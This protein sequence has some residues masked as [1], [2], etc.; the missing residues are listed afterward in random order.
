M[1][2]NDASLLQTSPIHS[3]I[4]IV[5]D[6]KAANSISINVIIPELTPSVTGT[7]ASTTATQAVTL[8]DISGNTINSSVNTGNTIT[9]YYHGGATNRKYPPDVVKGE[10]VQITKFANADKYYWESLGRDDALRKT[11]THRID[12]ANRANF[13]DP[14]DDDHTYSMEVDTKR[15]KHICIKTS[16]GN[17]EAFA[18][19]LMLNAGSGTAQLTDDNGNSVIINSAIA[20]IV[21]RNNKQAFFMLNG[22][23]VIIGAPRDFIMKA[24]RQVLFESPLITMNVTSGSGVLA[25]IANA[26]AMSAKSSITST[27]P[28]IGLNGA[29]QIPSILTAMNI[30]A[31][32]YANGAPGSTYGAASIALASAQATVP[33]VTP[34]TM[35]PA[36][37]RHAAAW[38][39]VSAALT[40]VVSCFDAIQSHIG[41]PTAQSGITPLSTDAQMSNLQGT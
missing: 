17:G 9:A 1:A 16:K 24:G 6:D 38:E 26:I 35:M 41:V 39:Q 20:Q 40:T 30:R 15:N 18:Y 27:A 19:Q 4:G 32:T 5:A 34:D 21:I 29:V 14:M 22:E 37:Q 13:N 7:V 8:T 25:I 2:V 33:N 23:D 12:V 28:A 11:E 36:S 31:E 10:Q 3:W